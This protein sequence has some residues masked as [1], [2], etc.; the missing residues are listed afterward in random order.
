MQDDLR[1]QM[2]GLRDHFCLFRGAEKAFW[3]REQLI[4]SAP[5]L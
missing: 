3:Q 5:L 2:H 4:A 1:M